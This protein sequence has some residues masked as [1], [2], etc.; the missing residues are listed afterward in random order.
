ME[1]KDLDKPHRLLHPV[2]HIPISAAD[3]AEEYLDRPL[4]ARTILEIKDRLIQLREKGAT[5][6]ESEIKVGSSDIEYIILLPECEI[7]RR[8]K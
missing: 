1:P 2:I 8:V 4:E 5:F 6:K 7:Y 3:V